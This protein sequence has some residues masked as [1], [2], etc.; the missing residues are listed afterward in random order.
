M[1]Q[2]TPDDPITAELKRLQAPIRGRRLYSWSFFLVVISALFLVPLWASLQGD[3]DS[4]LVKGRP[5]VD[6]SSGYHQP[7][8][9]VKALDVSWNSGPLA[10]AHQAWATDCKVCHSEPFK[11]VKDADCLTCHV[12]MAEHVT[13]QVKAETTELQVRC[14]TCHRDHNG[15]F[16]LDVQNKH[17]T[18]SACAQCHAEI[19]SVAPK[20]LTLD[21][22]D[23]DKHHPEFRVQ[24]GS[25]G[26]PAK[27]TRV[28][29]EKGVALKH[30]S[31]LKFPHDVHLT[32][33]GVNSPKGK[34]KTDCASCH[35]ESADKT[36]FKPVS[37][38]KH[39]HECHELRFEPTVSNRQVPHGPVDQVLSTLREFYS[40]IR[41]NPVPIEQEPIREPIKITR[42]GQAERPLASFIHMSGND[43]AKASAAAVELFEKTSCVVCHEVSRTDGPGKPSTTGKDLPQWKI[44]AVAASHVWMPQARFDHQAHTVAS[45]A[46]CHDAK[47]SKASEDVL[48]PAINVC[49]DCHAGSAPAKQR[50][51]SDCGVCHGFHIEQAHTPTAKT[52]KVAAGGDKR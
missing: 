10:R 13:A 6:K 40:F 47:K 18:Q 3:P 35:E 37:F 4:P 50:V 29:M 25:T 30:A 23:F 33:G 15:P 22:K 46:T 5:S 26:N 38:E 49:R 34:V 32:E 28:R 7:A 52:A 44:P 9:T 11:M 51:S 41:S 19:K 45:C 21:V 48:M 2:P 1:V 8:P 31:G 20:T 42:P 24:I 17:F 43:R 27:L 16:G 12:N 14:A 36:T 39:C